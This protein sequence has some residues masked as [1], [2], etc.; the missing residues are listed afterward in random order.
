MSNFVKRQYNNNYGNSNGNGNGNNTS[1]YNN[2]NNNNNNNNTQEKKEIIPNQ[3][4]EKKGYARPEKTFTDNLTEEQIQER[5]E[6]YE[7][8]KDIYT[9][10]LGT[11]MRYYTTDKK[12]GEKVF[13]MGGLL[14]HN[15]GLPKYVMLSNGPTQWSVQVEDAIFFKK[16]TIDDVKKLFK[17]EIAGLK[18]EIIK[19]KETN[20]NLMD[21]LKQ[22]NL[23]DKKKAK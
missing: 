4:Y 21:E 13:R 18:K 2:N 23:S 19:L 1:N 6:D 10:P 14:H 3:T 5:L 11:H 20:K 15:K 9:V 8:V 7:E 16:M 12:T 17:E 22:K